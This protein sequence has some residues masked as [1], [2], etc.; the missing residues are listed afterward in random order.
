MAYNVRLYEYPKILPIILSQILH[1]SIRLPHLQLIHSAELTSTFVP[2][3]A[4]VC[5]HGYAGQTWQALENK[6]YVMSWGS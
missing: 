6:N 1:A 3:L 4:H 2:M 5:K